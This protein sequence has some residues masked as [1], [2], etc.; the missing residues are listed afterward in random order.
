MNEINE[1]K[2]MRSIA[3]AHL[4]IAVAKADEKISGRELTEASNLAKNSQRSLNILNMNQNVKDTISKHINSIIRDSEY[5]SWD[6]N[7]HLEKALSIF[8][9]LLD[10]GE[11]SVKLTADKIEDGLRK[12]SWVDGYDL[13]ESRVV[14]KILSKLRELN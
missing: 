3:E 14:E 5:S 1:N 9:Q 6:W 13:N 10:D 7:A 2:T 12:L 4:Y 11:W 8:R